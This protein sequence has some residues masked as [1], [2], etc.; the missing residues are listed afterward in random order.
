VPDLL[1]VR[2]KGMGCPV[3]NEFCVFIIFVYVTYD[4]NLVFPVVAFL[5]YG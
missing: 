4:H 2:Y 1:D 5:F 3:S